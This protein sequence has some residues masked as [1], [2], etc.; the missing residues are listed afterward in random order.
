[1]IAQQLISADSCLSHDSR[2]FLKSKCEVLLFRFNNEV[3]ESCEFVRLEGVEVSIKLVG[4]VA[5]GD[6]KAAASDM[7][8][9]EVDLHSIPDLESDLN[10]RQQDIVGSQESTSFMPIRVQI[11][12][13]LDLKLKVIA[14][15]F[16]YDHLCSQRRILDL[17]RSI[18][19]RF[20]K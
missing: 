17:L 19:L 10:F 3:D 13:P 12:N 1:M 18:E 2:S 5:C 11:G 9:S 15:V 14:A 6:F 16:F 4:L 7:I 8:G 20:R